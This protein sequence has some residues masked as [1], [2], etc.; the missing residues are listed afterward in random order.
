MSAEPALY[1]LKLELNGLNL[2]VRLTAAV[3]AGRRHGP[4]RDPVH[5]RA[6]YDQTSRSN[7]R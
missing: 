4:S 3:Q 5:P 2:F 7:R 1:G 6:P